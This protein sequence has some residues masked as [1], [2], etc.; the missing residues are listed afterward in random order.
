MSLDLTSFAS[1][2]KQHYTDDRVVNM[3]YKD[4]PLLAMVKKYEQ[5]GG[6]N[7]PI[8]IIYGNPQGRSADFATA[9]ANKGSSKL[10]DFVLTRDHDYSLASIDNETL[11][12]SKGNAN[13]FMEA[14]TVEI[15]GAI[16]S[17]TRSLAVALYR[18]G[19]G[20]IGQIDASTNL[21]TAII[22][23]KN[24]EDVTN[25]EVG[26]VLEASTS[27][28]GGVVKATER[29][30][31]GIDRDLGTVTVDSVLNTGTAW[32]SQDFLF[33]EGDYDSKIK[34]LQAWIPN[35]APSNTPFFSVDRTSDVTRLGG[36]RFDGSNMPI[37][38][39]LISAA[40]RVGREGGRPD[41]CFMS[42]SKYA[43]L[44]KALGSKVQYIDVKVN[45]EVG[46]PG[47]LVHGPRGP[48]KVIPDQ[49]CPS[50]RAFMLQMNT[51]KLYSL[52]KA[53]KILDTDGLK[54]LRESSADAVEVRVGYYAQLGCNSPGFNCNIKLS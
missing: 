20:S 13:A 31:I 42:F 6:K 29:T 26:M 15:D 37:E 30:I 36:V 34:G 8:P 24:P 52:G 27:D 32:A 44:E 35:S 19:S 33:V 2:L 45:A 51:W 12:A 17:A 53:P 23:L 25:F 11:E 46:F 21:A 18:S 40:N 14:A 28:G 22:Q 48:I 16:Q 43:E 1:A 50:D 38:E 3:V 10:K 47:M 49:N 39:A 4:N 9:Q 5:F 7:L 54:M 41:V